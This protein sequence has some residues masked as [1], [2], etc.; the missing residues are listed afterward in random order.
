LSYHIAQLN[1]AKLNKPLDHKDNWRF[2]AYLDPINEFGEKTTGFIW[3]LKDEEGN[4]TSIQ[5]FNDPNM[6]VNLTVWENL[7]ALYKFTYTGEH[8][9]VFKDRSEWFSKMEAHSLV[10]W[11]IKSGHI[12]EIDEAKSKLA[13]INKNGPSPI[14]FN[15]RQAYDPNGIPYT[16]KR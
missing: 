1:I 12:P 8:S 10:I 16:L 6:I 15:F 5:A 14:A 4:A 3:R 7:E 13:H 11:W 9:F 2:N